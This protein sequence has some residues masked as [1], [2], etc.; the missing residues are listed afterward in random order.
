MNYDKGVQFQGNGYDNIYS[1]LAR[2]QE[3]PRRHGGCLCCGAMFIFV[4]MI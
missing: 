3:F 1:L 2:Q 4:W